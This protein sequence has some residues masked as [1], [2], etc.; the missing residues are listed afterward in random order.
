MLYLFAVV[1]GFAHGGMAPQGSPLL[2]RLFG[3]RSHGLLLGVV[4]I[5]FRIGAGIG[6]FVTGYIFDLTG[7]YQVA[8]LVCAASGIVSLILAAVLRPTTRLGGRI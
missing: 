5:G 3:L 8:F 7:S 2:A 4:G 6:P 1:F